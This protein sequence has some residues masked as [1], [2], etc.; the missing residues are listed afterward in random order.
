MWDYIELH[1]GGRIRAADL[2]ALAGYGEYYIT[3]LFKQETG[4]SINDYIK[5]AKIERA[6][7]LLA[8]TGQP[9]QQIADTLGFATRSYFSQC[10][11]QVVGQSPAEYRAS[12]QGAA[13]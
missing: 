12:V 8:S 6:K 13:K 11:K 2:A 9:L 10:F 1:L 4:Y 7:V 5:F 3:R